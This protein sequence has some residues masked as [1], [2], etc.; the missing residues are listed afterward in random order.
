MHSPKAASFQ[1][2]TSGGE[3]GGGGTTIPTGF[4]MHNISGNPIDGWVRAHGGTIGK[5]GSGGS[6]RAA[7]DTQ[8]LYQ[9]IWNT[10]PD[11]IC[12]VPSGRGVSAEADFSDGKYITL[13]DLR[14]RVIAAVQPA[15]WAQDVGPIGS[16]THTLIEAELPAVGAH[17]HDG[18]IY[19][20][21]G[22][23]AYSSD[24]YVAVEGGTGATSAAGGFG[25]GLAHNNVQPMYLVGGV[26]F[27]L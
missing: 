23:T 12:P 26:F 17:T 6:E 19:S 11:A 22:V 15:T 27:K 24:A 2:G 5:D 8:G 4:I 1:S 3:S 13:P 21:L 20:S 9:N 14:T 18:V 25:S 10:Y 16:E 7:D